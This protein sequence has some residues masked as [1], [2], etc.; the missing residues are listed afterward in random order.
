MRRAS[1]ALS[2]RVP[3]CADSELHYADSATRKIIHS[4]CCIRV[5]KQIN[6]IPV[7]PW[8]FRGGR[9]SIDFLCSKFFLFSNKGRP[10]PI[11]RPDM[12]NPFSPEWELLLCMYPAANE[13][14][15]QENS[16]SML[17]GT[18]IISH[19][20][21]GFHGSLHGLPRHLAGV[22]SLA[23]PWESLLDAVSHCRPLV[24]EAMA[25][26]QPP[27]AAPPAG[28]RSETA[29]VQEEWAREY[30]FSHHLYAAS[31]MRDMTQ[32]AGE[33]GLS[34]FYLA[35]KPGRFLARLTAAWTYPL[36][37]TGL[38]FV[39]PCPECMSPSTPPRFHCGRGPCGGRG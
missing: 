13:V 5:I 22:L 32:W 30:L 2:C 38:L 17:D 7:V 18:L 24:E 35:G 6:N 25:N 19:N 28:S 36:A 21:T 9:V 8:I 20:V 37:G 15:L 16:V 1:D 33:L 10:P 12:A 29:P 23:G 34:G 4:L 14:V 27:A 31:K 39:L 26:L 11:C 3:C